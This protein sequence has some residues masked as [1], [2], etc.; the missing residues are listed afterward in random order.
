ME[1]RKPFIAVIGA[2]QVGATTAQRVLEKSLCDVVLFDVVEGLPQGKALDLM[3]AASIEGYDRHILGTN[4]IADISGAEIVVMTAG[5]ARKPGMSREDLLT[6]NAKIVRD[7]CLNIRQH[8]PQAKLIMVTNPLDLMTQLAQEVTGFSPER[9]FGMAGVLD[10]ARMRFFI[11]DRL[12]KKP[13]A[14]DAMVLGG[15]G[16]LMVPVTS[17]SKT[18]GKPVRELLSTEAIQ[19]IETRTRNGGAEIVALLKTGGAFYA[20]ASAVAE[21]VRGVLRDEKLVC[22]VCARLSGE[23]GLRDIY[24][25]VPA[26]LGKNGVESIVEI[27]LE[28]QEKKALAL[29]AQKVRQGLDEIRKLMA[30]N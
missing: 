29:S 21:M 18:E 5:L 30:K 3:Q 19:A 4:T 15:H 25:G 1:I 2:G 6:S 20:P 7:V 24:F 17:Q 14:I 28:D 26:K 9:V 27:A 22:P 13:A 8:A 10:A 23:Y 11:A 16:D 12:G